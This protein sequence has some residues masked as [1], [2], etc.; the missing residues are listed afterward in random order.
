MRNTCLSVTEA[1]ELLEL[2][3]DL[4]VKLNSGAFRQQCEKGERISCF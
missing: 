3:A 4:N 2:T 1:W